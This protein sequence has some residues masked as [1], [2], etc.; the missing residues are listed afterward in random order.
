MKRK[1]IKIAFVVAIA[2]VSGINVFNAQKTVVLSDVAMENVE[3]LAADSEGS[4]IPWDGF[5][6][7]I[8]NSCCKYVGLWS[9]QCSGKYP[10][11]K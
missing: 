8:Q 11:C 4:G 7:D 10:G 5:V 6:L 9:V 1:M 3:A 2:L